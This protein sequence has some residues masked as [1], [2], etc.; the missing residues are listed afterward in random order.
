MTQQVRPSSKPKILIIEDEEDIRLLL[1]YNLEQRGFTVIA[2]ATGEEGFQKTL[3]S[4]PDLILLDWMLPDTEG[5]DI[6]RQIRQ[7]APSLIA[8]TPIIMLTAKSEEDNKINALK[9]GADDYLTKP[10]S[11]KELIARIEA[12]LRRS[13][14]FQHKK[15]ILTCGDIKIDLT[16]QQAF[17]N[18]EKL[19]LSPIEYKILTLFIQN[20]SKIFSRDELIDHIW[21]VN[22]SI[23]PRTIDVN[24]KRLRKILDPQHPDRYI[25]TIR[26]TGY[27]CQDML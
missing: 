19:K 20:P 7:N 6:C 14:D 26:G 15:D 27:K 11:I 25:S 3:S 10:F 17:R 1:S 9:T 16:Q 12:L 13:Q 22:H 2:S 18:E 24:I 21:G 8:K 23:E 5:I 4:T